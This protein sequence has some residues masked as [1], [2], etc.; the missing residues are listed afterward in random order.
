MRPNQRLSKPGMDL[1]ATS[2]N[3]I[4]DCGTSPKEHREAGPHDVDANQLFGYDAID[5]S[6]NKVGPVDSVWVDA[7]G[8]LEFVGVKTGW[9]MVKIH[10]LPTA[11][12]RI[13]NHTVRVPYSEDQIKDFP[14]FGGGDFGYR[15]PGGGDRR[16]GHAGRTRR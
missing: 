7:T 2:G 8:E 4:R 16:D 5:V 6:G 9:L 12:A 14:S 3:R 1:A 13:E 15:L 11:N 10:V